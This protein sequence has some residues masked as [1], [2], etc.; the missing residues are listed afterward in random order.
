MNKMADSYKDS[1]YL[2]E[3]SATFGACDRGCKNFGVFLALTI[4]VLFIAFLAAT[5]HKI[6]VL[7]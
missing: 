6:L 2:P 3:G 7:R 1:D 5:P 4:P